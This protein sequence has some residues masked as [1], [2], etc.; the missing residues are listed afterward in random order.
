M[1]EPVLNFF[2]E[3]S[4]FQIPVNRSPNVTKNPNNAIFSETRNISVNNDAYKKLGNRLHNLLDRA[5]FCYESEKTVSG[6]IC[7]RIMALYHQNSQL[8]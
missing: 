8:L 6:P 7:S 2:E 5:H 1:V 4:Y 3:R